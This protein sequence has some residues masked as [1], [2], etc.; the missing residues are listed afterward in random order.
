M[1]P[2]SLLIVV[3]FLWL[4]QRP[5]DALLPL[6]AV[7]NWNQFKCNDTKSK[8]G[9]QRPN[10][11][12]MK[13]QTTFY[14]K[15][16]SLRLLICEFFYS[17]DFAYFPQLIFFPFVSEQSLEQGTKRIERIWHH[18]LSRSNCEWSLYINNGIHEKFRS[19]YIMHLRRENCLYDFLITE[20]IANEWATF[21]NFIIYS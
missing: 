6:C 2:C 3:V 7:F 16:M 10:L 18:E 17:V 9:N 5:I 4:I 21:M 1:L 13:V 11:R 14:L 12:E 15:Q 20:K 19:P 8:L